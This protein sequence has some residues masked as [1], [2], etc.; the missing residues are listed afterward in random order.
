MDLSEAKSIKFLNHLRDSP[1]GSSILTPPANEAAG[2]ALLKQV[3]AICK[4]KGGYAQKTVGRAGVDVSCQNCSAG[5]DIIKQVLPDKNAASSSL[6]ALGW[7]VG[8]GL[9]VYLIYSYA[10]KK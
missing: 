1:C 8:A 2:S 5:H 6:G 9:G 7:I 10:G 3:D 4:S